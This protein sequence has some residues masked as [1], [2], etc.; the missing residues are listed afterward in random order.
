MRRRQAPGC[1]P[2]ER[3][4]RAR[5]R[6]PP[7]GG[8]VER[9][10]PGGGVQLDNLRALASRTPGALD[11]RLFALLNRQRTHP[12]LDWLLP[13]LTLLGLGGIQ[14]PAVGIVW[15]LRRASAAG[16]A[17]WWQSLLVFA[18]TTI[19]VHLVKRRVKRKRPVAHLE[20]RFLVPVTR[21]GSFPS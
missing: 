21:A 17:L 20:V 10:S 2:F 3:H 6:L 1:P 13:R 19:A 5:G 7:G 14:L 8:R 12:L 16:R 18:L 4:A 9:G 11:L 15:W